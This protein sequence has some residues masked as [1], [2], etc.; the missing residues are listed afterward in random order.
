MD[1]NNMPT[2]TFADVKSVLADATRRLD[3]K[4]SAARH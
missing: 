1:F 3:A 4:L 2:T